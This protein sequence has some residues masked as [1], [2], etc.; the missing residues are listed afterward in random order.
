MS[1][2][3]ADMPRLLLDVKE[4]A[5]M[6]GICRSSMYKLIR[7]GEIESVKVGRLRKVEPSAVRDYVRRLANKERAA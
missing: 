6:I 1:T 5:E 4:A 7:Q 2:P 3:P